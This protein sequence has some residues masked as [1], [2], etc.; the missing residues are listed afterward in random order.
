MIHGLRHHLTPTLPMNP[1][2]FQYVNPFTAA[3]RG[4]ARLLVPIIGS[5]PDFA[6]FVNLDSMGSTEFRPSTN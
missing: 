3:S 2:Q 6:S 4:G 1:R 5:S